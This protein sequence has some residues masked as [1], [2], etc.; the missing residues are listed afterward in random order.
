MTKLVKKTIEESMYIKSSLIKLEKNSIKKLTSTAKIKMLELSKQN[1]KKK[2]NSR[3][4][5]SL[6]LAHRIMVMKKKTAKKEF[7]PRFIPIPKINSSKKLNS[8]SNNL[9]KYRIHTKDLIKLQNLPSR[10]MGKDSVQRSNRYSAIYLK[11]YNQCP[12]ESMN[13]FRDW[14]DSQLGRPGPRRNDLDLF[15]IGQM[16]NRQ[17]RQKKFKEFKR[18]LDSRHPF[19]KQNFGIF[20]NTPEF[21]R[22]GEMPRRLADEIF[23]QRKYL[24]GVGDESGIGA[25]DAKKEKEQKNLLQKRSHKEFQ[26]EQ[27]NPNLMLKYKKTP[28]NNSH[29][30]FDSSKSN[31]KQ[32]YSINPKF[33]VRSVKGMHLKKISSNAN[34]QFLSEDNIPN[35]DKKLANQYEKKKTFHSNEIIKM[36]KKIQI[37]D[38]KETSDSVFRK[39]VLELCKNFT[40]NK[41]LA[42]C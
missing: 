13:I 6:D 42:P 3:S 14:Y 36:L 31:T 24:T 2:A 12:L 41:N 5:S 22:F 16:E 8:D 23:L 9:E 19:K 20:F 25:E 27:P 26:D 34:N 18:G 7:D 38:L 28:F 10:K 33:L 32:L 1:K 17:T 15:N 40:V 29:S 30:F 37:I 11:Y 21:I 35:A 39:T 4:N